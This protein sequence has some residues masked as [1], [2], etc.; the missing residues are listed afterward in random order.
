MASNSNASFS[1]S[2]FSEITQIIHNIKKDEKDKKKV[3]KIGPPKPKLLMLKKKNGQVKRQPKPEVSKRIVSLSREQMKPRTDDDAYSY[4]RGSQNS[5]D[6]H[7]DDSDISEASASLPES[8]ESMDSDLSTGSESDV[9]PARSS[10]VIDYEYKNNQERKLRAMHQVA[11]RHLKNNNLNLAGEKFEEILSMLVEEYG[12]KCSRVGTAVHNLGVVHLRDNNYDAASDAFRTAISIRSKEL[13][14]FNPKV[15]DSMVELGIVLMQQEDFDESI[16]VLNTALVIREVE[17][18]EDSDDYDTQVQT[19]LKLAKIHNNIGC[20]YFECDE[21][22]EAREYFESSLEIQRDVYEPGKYKSQPGYLAMSST[23]CNLGCV[24]LEMSDWELACQFLEEALKIQQNILNP[25]SSM[26]LNTME[27]LGYAF[28]K[29]ADYDAGM[30][31]YKELVEIRKKNLCVD[32]LETAETMKNLV[33][34]QIKLFN[35]EDAFDTLRD[36]EIIQELNYDEDDPRLVK[37]RELLRDAHYEM[38]KFPGLSEMITRMI[39]LNG[40]RNPWNNDLLCQCSIDKSS[41]DF[42]LFK[43][44]CRPQ[45]KTKLTGHK[46]SYA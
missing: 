11:C 6:E 44:E 38:Y 12:D 32:D 41:D 9:Q 20:V 43:P 4:T 28:V 35:Y 5:F 30:K 8:C 25:T 34:C 7:D 39:T 37:T 3:F 13:G 26:A 22:D 46:I 14:E 36:I 16:D 45:V 31:V 33:Y 10:K 40:Y 19:Q 23:V 27:H 24:Y 1:P 15:A 42:S 29:Y 17:A 2:V 18:E 21:L